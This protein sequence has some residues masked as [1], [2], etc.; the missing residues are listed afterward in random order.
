M[1][2][3]R[4]KAALVQLDSKTD[5]QR[6]R[7]AIQAGLAEA[8]RRGAQLAVLPETA[9]YIGA[10][11]AGYA[12]ACQI[13]WDEFFSAQAKKYGIYLH[14][15]SITSMSGNGKLYN[16][17]CFY[18][19]GGQKLGQYEKLHMFDIA[20]SDG[21]AYRESDMIS[22][23]REI[24]LLDTALGKMGL[25]IC[26]DL[27]FPE[28]F[29]IMAQKGARMIIIPANFTDTTG[30]AHWEPL[31]RARAIE[32]GCYVLACGQCGRKDA[33]EAHGH[34]MIISPWGEV[35]AQ[36]QDQPGCITAEIDLTYIDKVRSQIPVLDNI[37]SDIYQ[38]GS[39]KIH[40]YKE[41]I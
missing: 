7:D 26:Y 38:L 3:G 40:I 9:D 8:A 29:R 37:R 4:F 30:K 31:L 2:Q 19:P 13:E 20:V 15:G 33:F 39:P 32:N 28:L 12:A 24:S 27:R 1:G 35:I 6:N 16:T 21:T 25:A 18:L 41:E 14:A 5:V 11:F 36:A 10:D 23:G 34:S 17:S 22:P